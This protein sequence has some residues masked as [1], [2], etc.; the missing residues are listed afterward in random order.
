MT[1]AYPPLAE[2]PLTFRKC[3]C[4]NKMFVLYTIYKV[5]TDEPVA[6]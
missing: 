4:L 6:E 3:G 1:E 5:Q 2:I